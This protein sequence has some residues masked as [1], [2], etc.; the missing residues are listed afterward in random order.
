MLLNIFLTI[1]GVSSLAGSINTMVS[2]SLQVILL[3]ISGF[4]VAVNRHSICWLRNMVA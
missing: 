3:G 4:L 1:I 2:I